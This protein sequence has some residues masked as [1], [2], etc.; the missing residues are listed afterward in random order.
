MFISGK[1]LTTNNDGP[2]CAYEVIIDS[3]ND[4]KLAQELL[5]AADIKVLS[6]RIIGHFAI[7][8]E[9][10]EQWETIGEIQGLSLTEYKAPN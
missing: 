7:W 10:P 6:A 8:L 1:F 2:P 5:R 9:K 4:S 3:D